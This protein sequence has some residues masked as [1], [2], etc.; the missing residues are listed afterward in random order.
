MD[1]FNNLYFAKF[2]FTIEPTDIIILPE[3]KGSVFRGALGKALRNFLCKNHNENCGCIYGQIFEPIASVEEQEFLSIGKDKPRGFILEPP[4]TPQRK[5]VKGEILK[6]NLILVGKMLDYI[7]F[8]IIIFE[9]IGKKYGLGEWINGSRG[10]FN[11]LKVETDGYTVYSYDTKFFSSDF[12]KQ[13][14]N[15]LSSDSIKK[16]ILEINFITPTRIEILGER[17]LLNEKDSFEIF[18]ENLYRRA[19]LLNALYCLPKE[20]LLKYES[21]ILKKLIVN[22]QLLSS[23]L[24]VI[25][26]NRFARNKSNPHSNSF[27]CNE[28]EE[29]DKVKVKNNSRI[30]MHYDGFTGSVKYKCEVS[31]FI[32]LIKLGEILHIG[33]YTTFGF[34]KYEIL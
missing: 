8:F 6:F 30:L 15:D 9:Q 13:S 26:L 25:P 16:D 11:L 21:E 1:I 34:G 4:N 7:P 29:P 10:K 28:I 20:G 3:F 33:K 17:K 27:N 31:Q 18:F 5:F 19:F 2:E 12:K 14:F 32:K 24:K 23:N 22:I